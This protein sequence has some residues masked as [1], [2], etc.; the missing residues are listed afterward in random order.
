MVSK[1]NQMTIT[2]DT[3]RKISN[4]AKISI[5]DE[6]VEKLE[7]E[8]SSIIRWVEALNEV[9]TE[10][11]DPM[12]NSLTG[13]L[14]MREDLVTDGNKVSDILSNSPV[15]DENFFVVPKVIE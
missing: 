12:S 7:S 15:D 13:G 11:V 8:I 14:R 5:A 4:L 2:K 3:I 6:E 1:V 9:D 10:N